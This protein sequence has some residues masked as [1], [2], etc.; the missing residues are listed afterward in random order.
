MAIG[1][2]EVK[3]MLETQS[4][5]IESELHRKFFRVELRFSSTSVGGLLYRYRGTSPESLLV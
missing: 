2:L 1:V 5:L 3:G 4:S